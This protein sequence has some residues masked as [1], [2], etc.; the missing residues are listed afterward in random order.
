[1]TDLL[2]SQVTF[3]KVYKDRLFFDRFH[4]CMRGY[5]FEASALRPKRHDKIDHIVDIRNA[6]LNRTSQQQINN[7]HRNKLHNAL[8]VINSIT[9]DLKITISGRL[10]YFYA[11][12][13]SVF[14][15]L[16][17]SNL[18]SNPLYSEAVV[19]IPRNT[20]RLKNPQYQYRTFL[21]QKKVS[22]LEMQ[23]LKSFFKNNEQFVKISKSLSCG[24]K[25]ASF[26]LDRRY[27]FDH[28]DNRLLIMLNVMCPGVIRSTLEFA[29]TK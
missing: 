9:S 17:D 19:A 15:T 10:I 12:D 24:L 18:F 16:T 28:S 3:K 23:G 7:M 13:L 27:F 14:K 21:R 1:M 22:N 11:N 29:E 2:F 5:L 20:I 4:Y 25:T 26:Y 8:D 6:F